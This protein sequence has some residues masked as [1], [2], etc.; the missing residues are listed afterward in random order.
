MVKKIKD[1]NRKR[2][3]EDYQKLGELIRNENNSIIKYP[4]YKGAFDYVESKF[5]GL[6]VLNVTVYKVRR[7]ELIEYGYEGVGGLYIPGKRAV[8]VSE[9]PSGGNTNTHGSKSISAKLSIDE[10]IVHELL[11]YVSHK[12][13]RTHDIMMEEEFAYGHSVPYLSKK[14]MSEEDI[15]KYNMLPFLY[16]S[17]NHG[18]LLT[19]ILEEREIKPNTYNSYLR[20]YEAKTAIQP[21][22]D[23]INV[24][25]N[26]LHER[27]IELA[28]KKGEFLVDTYRSVP[29]GEVN[30]SDDGDYGNLEI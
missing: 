11:H 10:V 9:L 16:S 4:E 26:E 1:G 20:K 12:I 29:D 27:T 23:T 22:I 6:N 13:Y 30:N 18:K 2:L 25:R 24:V 28:M 14:G 5:P 17:V 21:M 7:K 19:K 15:I 3:S 8:I